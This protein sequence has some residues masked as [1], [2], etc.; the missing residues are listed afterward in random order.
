MS[1]EEALLLVEYIRVTIDSDSVIAI[2]WDKILGDL[3]DY[4]EKKKIEENEAINNLI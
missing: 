3:R 4:V 1:K 2:D